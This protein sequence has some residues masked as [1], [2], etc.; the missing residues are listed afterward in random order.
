[1]KNIKE[2]QVGNTVLWLLGLIGLAVIA[3]F[4]FKSDRTS[5]SIK[6]D[7]PSKTELVV[8]EGEVVCLPNRNTGGLT[9]TECVYGVKTDDGKYY[10][11]DGASLSIDRQSGYEVGQRVAFEGTLISQSNITED[12]WA[13]YNITGLMKVEDYWQFRDK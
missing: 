2:E 11:L 13:A 9:T 12:R 1:M 4:V 3:F 10:G 8:L 6:L 5:K 7:E